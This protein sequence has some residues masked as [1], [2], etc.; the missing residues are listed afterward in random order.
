[1]GYWVINLNGL[2]SQPEPNMNK[3]IKQ[4]MEGYFSG[5]KFQLYPTHLL[6]AL[7]WVDPFN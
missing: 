1:M 3:L 4:I 5:W 2:S 6:N 7:T